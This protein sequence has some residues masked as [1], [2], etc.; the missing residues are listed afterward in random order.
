MGDW[1]RGMAGLERVW[2]V[3]NG[4]LHGLVA[5][6]TAHSYWCDGNGIAALLGCLRNIG[7]ASDSDNRA[8]ARYCDDS[9]CVLS[10]RCEPPSSDIQA[11]ESRLSLCLNHPSVSK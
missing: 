6:T 1:G 4:D 10:N 2:E 11:L 9:R 3:W 7:G 8:D 5:S